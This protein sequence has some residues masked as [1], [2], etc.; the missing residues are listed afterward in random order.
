MPW[1]AVNFGQHSG[2]ILPQIAF[3]DP[4][5]FFWA[6]EGNVFKG[7]LSLEAKEIDA[8]ARSIRIPNNKAGDLIAEYVVHQPTGK[9]AHMRIVPA[10]QPNHEGASR[11]I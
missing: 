1:L 9:F 8:K 2:K 7:R 11:M 10:S 4:D 6:I 3:C 5:W